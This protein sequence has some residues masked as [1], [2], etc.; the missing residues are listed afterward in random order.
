MFPRKPYNTSGQIGGQTSSLLNYN[1]AYNYKQNSS[2]N[3]NASNSSNMF[4][5]LGQRKVLL[6][7]PTQH[8]I[9][10]R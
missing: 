1:S 3:G 8:P 4:L 5:V 6:E 10:M 9:A 7:S 2:L